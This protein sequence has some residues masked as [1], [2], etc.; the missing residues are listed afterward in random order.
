MVT[1][2]N[3]PVL[4]LAS[5]DNAEALLSINS[6]SVACPVRVISPEEV[7]PANVTDA[8]LVKSWFILESSSTVSVL[9]APLYVN[10][11]S[12]PSPIVK[13][14]F[15]VIVLRPPPVFCPSVVP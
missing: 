4:P 8:S 1:I 3:I 7:T 13:D 6:T 10:V 12:L 14:S 11:P 5:N 9:D 15:K 2:S